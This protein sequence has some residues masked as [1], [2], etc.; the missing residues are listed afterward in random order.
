MKNKKTKKNA[1][2]QKTNSLTSMNETN[3]NPL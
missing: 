1:G 2:L 3:S